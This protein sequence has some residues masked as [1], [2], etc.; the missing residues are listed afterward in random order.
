[1]N[2]GVLNK[3]T[4]WLVVLSLAGL[5]A[6]L[7]AEVPAYDRTAAKA[8]FKRPTEI[9]FPAEN[10]PTVA[11][12]SLGKALFFDTRLS[13][14]NSTACASCHNPAFSWSDALPRGVG[15]GSKELGRRTPTLINLAWGEEYF[16]DGRA[17]SLEEQALGPIKSAGE[18][19]MPLDKMVE[20]IKAIHGYEP[21]FARAYAG[22]GINEKVI[23]KAIATYERTLVSGTAPFDDWVNGREEA[24]PESAKR[25]FDVFNTKG[26]CVQCHTGWNF[27]D[28]GFHDIGI[29]DNDL[30][31][32]KVLPGIPAVLHAFKTPTLRNVSQ[33]GPYLHNG[34]EKT[35]PE[36]IS[37]YNQ[38]GSVKRDSVDI[39][40]RPLNL[41]ASEMRDLND[42]LLTL[43]SED[44]PVTI[45][46]L[47]NH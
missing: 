38:G 1:M 8:A 29:D 30:G 17:E 12:E 22:E 7:R 14:A 24:I 23:A 16:W 21:M 32:G 33:R 2:G 41:T 5:A 46:L 44:Q 26:L 13:G 3:M 18:M 43:S 15:F 4:G 25:G 6:Q 40:I 47:P 39:N 37:L 36:V 20:K 35:L 10:A 45:P 27:T 28:D 9:P 19:N 31:R 42:F 34:S 11:R